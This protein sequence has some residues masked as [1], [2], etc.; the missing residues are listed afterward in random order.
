MAISVCFSQNTRKSL[1]DRRKRLAKEIEQTSALLSQT[2]QNREATYSNYLTLQRQIGKRQQLI[3]TLQS[4]VIFL[5][6]SIER[7][8]E[9]VGIL[10]DDIERLK[11]DYANMARH[12]YRQNLVHSDWLFLLSS[13]S[14]NDA[15]RRWQ[16]LKQ[17]DRYRQKQA[18]LVLETQK[19]LIFKINLLEQK[20]SEKEQLLLSERRHTQMLDHELSSKNNLLSELKN[21]EVRL[22]RELSTKKKAEA[23][24]A[25]AIESIIREEVEKARRTAEK[26]IPLAKK[27][28]VSTPVKKVAENNLSRDFHYNRGRLPWPANGVITS[29]FGNQPHPVI[30]NIQIANNGIDIRTSIGADVKAVFDGEVV[31]TQYVPGFDYMVILKHG[32]YYTVYSKLESVSV[33]KGETVKI[34]QGIGKVSTDWETNTS[35]LHFELW[36]DKT[37]LNPADWVSDN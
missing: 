33:K 35:E 34:R 13:R 26:P 16:Y 3:L 9:V 14:F 19:S 10:A 15:F 28:E 5:S 2:K 30:K 20:K 25:L 11:E 29:T 24:L 21:D 31:G 36:K 22:S 23:N 17:F 4:E 1:E 32:D 7:S 8:N 18:N 37:R 12:A 6:E 27:E